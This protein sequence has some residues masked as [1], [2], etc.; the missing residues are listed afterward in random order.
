MDELCQSIYSLMFDKI[1]CRKCNL[2]VY[3]VLFLVLFSIFFLIVVNSLA[4]IIFSIIT[5]STVRT[6]WSFW[7]PFCNFLL[8]MNDDLTVCVQCWRLF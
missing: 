8:I 1:L 2:S 3:W 6:W 4:L 5:E 7:T